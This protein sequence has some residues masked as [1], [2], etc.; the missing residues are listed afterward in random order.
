VNWRATGAQDGRVGF[1]GG[2][3]PRGYADPVITLSILIGEPVSKAD[4]RTLERMRE[5]V[6]VG[7]PI[8]D[9][10]LLDEDGNEVTPTR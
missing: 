3:T 2:L 10:H 8:T 4:R 6:R 5:R 1:P 9:V 7:L